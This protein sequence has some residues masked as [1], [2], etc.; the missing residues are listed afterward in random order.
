MTLKFEGY[1]QSQEVSDFIQRIVV[2]QGHVT[3][4]RYPRGHKATIELTAFVP[5]QPEL[6]KVHENTIRS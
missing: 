4:V 5:N 3:G 6:I 2:M 1:D